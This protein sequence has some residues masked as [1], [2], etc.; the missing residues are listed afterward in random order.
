MLY[1]ASVRILYNYVSHI[2]YEIRWS[3]HNETKIDFQFYFPFLFDHCVSRS[4]D[5]Y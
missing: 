1:F 2:A 5:K 4:N 3:Q